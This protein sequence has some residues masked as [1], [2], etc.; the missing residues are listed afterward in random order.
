[1]QHF[2]WKMA[3]EETTSKVFVLIAGHHQNAYCKK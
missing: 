2:A 1:M 3:R